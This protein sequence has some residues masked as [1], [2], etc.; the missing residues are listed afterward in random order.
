M[1]KV[2]IYS[3][4]IWPS[5]FC[6][7]SKFFG[8]QSMLLVIGR[9]SVTMAKYDFSVG[10]TFGHPS[11]GLHQ[12]SK[13][14]HWWMIYFIL[15]SEFS[16]WLWWTKTLGLLRAV[17]DS[18]SHSSFKKYYCFLRSLT[19]NFN[20]K[21]LLTFSVLVK[22]KFDHVDFFYVKK[23]YMSPKSNPR[24]TSAST[25]SHVFFYPVQRACNLISA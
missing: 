23:S 18:F 5:V 14:K 7:Q 16:H 15:V 22:T 17:N 9:R 11:S 1:T 21:K 12:F 2:V 13:K 3:S 8:H 19:L 4:R 10:K 25:N 6:H 20:S 24:A